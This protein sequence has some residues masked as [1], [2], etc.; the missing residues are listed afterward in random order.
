MTN[1]RFSIRALKFISGKSDED[2]TQLVRQL[3][4]FEDAEEEDEDR[5]VVL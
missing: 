3:I 5:Y 1:Y 4:T 2:V